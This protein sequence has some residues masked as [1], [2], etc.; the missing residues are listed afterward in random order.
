MR[1]INFITKKTGHNC[2]IWQASKIKQ[3]HFC[4]F[5]VRVNH[6]PFQ[7]SKLNS[8]QQT[9]SIMATSQLTYGLARTEP[10]KIK[11]ALKLVQPPTKEEQHPATSQFSIHRVKFL[12]L[13]ALGQQDPLRFQNCCTFQNRQSLFDEDQFQ[14]SGDRSR[15]KLLHQLYQPTPPTAGTNTANEK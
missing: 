7:Q 11:V 6:R 12:H 2:K 14:S 15:R 13:T 8:T 3:Q 9:L 10:R 4:Q 5:H 1:K